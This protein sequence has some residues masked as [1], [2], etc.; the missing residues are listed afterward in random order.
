MIMKR[1]IE[2]RLGSGYIHYLIDNNY[3]GMLVFE[4]GEL[5]DFRAIIRKNKLNIDIQNLAKTLELCLYELLNQFLVDREHVELDELQTIKTHIVK[6]NSNV[7][8]AALEA[9]GKQWP[10]I[11]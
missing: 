5:S 9:I 6:T 3:L 4:K 10:V 8:S 2:L 11:K 1:T 7:L